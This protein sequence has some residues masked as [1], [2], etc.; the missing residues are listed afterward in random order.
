MIFSSEIRDVFLKYNSYSKIDIPLT[1][2]VE[3]NINELKKIIGTILPSSVI[4]NLLT[5]PPNESNFNGISLSYGLKA[6]NIAN[7][8][9]GIIDLQPS[10]HQVK[11]YL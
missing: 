10:Y 3:G 8:I 9:K 11:E 2:I 5:L 6:N 7:E 4:L 1:F